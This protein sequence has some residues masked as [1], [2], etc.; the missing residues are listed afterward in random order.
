MKKTTLLVALA[1][2]CLFAGAQTDFP[3]AEELEHPHFCGTTEETQKVYEQFPEYAIQDSLDDLTFEVDYQN[4]IESWS[5]DDRSS[6]II[7]VVVHV[8]H[9]GGP[10]NI[11]D[12]Q[13]YNALENL[14]DDFNK[15]N[16]DLG[17]TIPEFA[18]ITGNADIEFRLATKDN[19]GNCHPGITRT[20]SETTY[21]EGM[22]DGGHAIV[23]AVQEAQGNWPQNKYMNVFV[24]IDPSGNAG[25]TYRPGNW[26]PAAGMYGSIFMRHDYM[27]VIGT[28]NEGRRHTLSHE[29]GHWLNLAH[30]WGNTNT[31][32]DPDNCGT[33]DGVDDTP[34]TIGWTNCSDLYGE[35]CGS[36]D[37][38]Q[39]I[40]DYSY[41]STMFTELQAARIQTAL[42]GTRGQRY[43]LITP[44]NLAATGVDSDGDLCEAEFISNQRV[45]CAGQS[46]DFTD[47]SYHDVETRAWVFD[48]GMPA[49]STSDAPTITYN[50]PGKYTVTLTVAN[51]IDSEIETKE[52]YIIVLP[53]IGIGPAIEEG[54]ETFT[55]FPDDEKFI[56]EDDGEDG[57]WQLTSE[58]TYAGDKAIWLNNYD[59]NTGAKDAVMSG[60]IDLSGVDPSDEIIF[61]FKYAYKRRYGSNDEWIRFYISKDCGE[62]WILRKNLHGDDLGPEIQ[63]GE[64]F[65][66]SPSEWRS[67]D[68]TTINSSYFVSNFRYR[69]EFE[70]DNGNNIFIDNINLY[71]ASYASLNEEELTL[72]I[73]V[74]PHPLLD[75]AIIKLDLNSADNYTIKL[76]NSLGAEISNIYEGY[77]QA[78]TQTINWSSADLAPGMYLLR[79]ESEGK[80]QTV[81]L[82]K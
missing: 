64:Y 55:S 14:N 75:N 60:T 59:K 17:F 79:V 12:E 3:T 46:I 36:L 51:G 37:N 42:L 2:M 34:N 74:Y 5:P 40:M 25:Y 44:T 69:I 35:T 52:E 45:I 80:I 32:G 78:G 49:T 65:P 11:S 54:F 1:N 27:G 7:P 13:I 31:P 16:D 56:I 72:D 28:S 4:F 50:T 26:Y 29:C 68:I 58:Y 66:S 70:N 10:E 61:N 41:C 22:F 33:D 82:I 18:G 76:Y 20:F 9:L 21:D 30:P 71:P 15:E 62:T 73:S 53:N 24:C 6:Y 23:E 8:V 77:L 57:S 43:K 38:V 19:N 48:G 67:V 39:N 81:K 47:L 63:E